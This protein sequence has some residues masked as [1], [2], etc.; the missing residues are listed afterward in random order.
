M[1]DNTAAARSMVQ[2]MNCQINAMELLYHAQA[3]R[4]G[5]ADSVFWVLY[6][7]RSTRRAYT[8]NELCNEWGFPKQT[9]NSAVRT[10]AERGLLRLDAA[11][12][13]C[14]RKQLHLTEAGLALAART[15]D[16]LFTAEAAALTELSPDNAAQYLAL[17][18]QHYRLLCQKFS[19]LTFM[20]DV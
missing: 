3:Q 20:E 19:E 5:L 10:L 9:L 1:N 8:Q 16:P 2:Q 6:A 14:N 4:M 11:P 13:P 18:A 15:I 17:Q 7:L 12:G